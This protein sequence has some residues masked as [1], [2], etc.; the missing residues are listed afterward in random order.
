[1]HKITNELVRKYQVLYHESTHWMGFNHKT[2]RVSGTKHLHR[3][4]TYKAAYHGREMVAIPQHSPCSQVC[5]NCWEFYPVASGKMGDK[6]AVCPHCGATHHRDL[7][8]ARN[9]LHVGKIAT[10]EP[11][12]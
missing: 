11:T 3:F 5:S 10:V 8:A 4:L 1:M 2:F 12:V 9:I 6:I 7:N